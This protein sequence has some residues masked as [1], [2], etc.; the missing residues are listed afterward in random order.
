MAYLEDKISEILNADLR[1][2]IAAEV[3]K[4]KKGTRFGLVFEEHQPEVLSIPDAPVKRGERVAQKTGKLT[5]TWRVLKVADDQ[6][7]CE[8]EQD[9]TVRETFPYH[10]P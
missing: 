10:Y 6:A 8:Q 4:L 2:A 1:Q 9:A 5:E 7:L 3:A